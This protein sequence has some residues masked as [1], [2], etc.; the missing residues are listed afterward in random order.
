MSFPKHTTHHGH[1]QDVLIK[2][3]LQIK[4]G[5]VWVEDE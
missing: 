2:G 1:F 5:P 3:K 4:I